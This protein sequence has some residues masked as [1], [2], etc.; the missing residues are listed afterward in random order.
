MKEDDLDGQRAKME[1]T[2]NTHYF[3]GEISRENHLKPNIRSRIYLFWTHMIA[4]ALNWHKMGSNCGL[5][6]IWQ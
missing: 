5:L 2:I 1:E 3:C 6:G 4:T